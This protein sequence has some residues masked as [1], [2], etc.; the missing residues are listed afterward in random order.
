MAEWITME[1]FGAD[2]PSNWEEI[3][4]YLNG[5]IDGTD[6][7]TDADG[8]LTAEGR[9]KIDGIWERYWSD[10]HSGE[11]KDAPVPVVE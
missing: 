4:A 3:A 1:S 7:I 11:L 2:C 5:I 6:G 10:Y 9:E 8:E